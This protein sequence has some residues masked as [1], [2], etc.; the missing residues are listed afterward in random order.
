MDNDL[1]VHYFKTSEM[2]SLLGTKFYWRLSIKSE[3]GGP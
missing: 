2:E 3:K 1:M